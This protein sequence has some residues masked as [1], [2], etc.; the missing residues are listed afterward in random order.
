MEDR[1]LS[2]AEREALADY[3]RR[4]EECRKYRSLFLGAFV[5]WLA[6]AIPAGF[7]ALVVWVYHLWEMTK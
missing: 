3:L 4:R 2:Q 7:I 5:Q 6:A 1:P